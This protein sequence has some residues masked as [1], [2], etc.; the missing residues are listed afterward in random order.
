MK[1]LLQL[2]GVLSLILWCWICA[3]FTI[4]AR[5]TSAQPQIELRL[6]WCIREAW[7]MRN[8]FD[9]YLVVGNILLFIPLGFILSTCFESMR[10]SWKIIL[11]SFIFSLMIE[12]LQLMLHRGLFELDDLFNNTL[13]GILGYG[14]TI[15]FMGVKERGNISF[16]DKTLNMVLWILVIIFVLI[17]LLTGQPVFDFFRI[18]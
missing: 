16:A 10:K 4:F 6:F 15:I 5:E 18:I 11:S 12:L 1:R 13:G 7:T 3:W 2:T 8:I 17:A 9:W 14:I